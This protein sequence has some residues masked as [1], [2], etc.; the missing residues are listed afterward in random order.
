M[1]SFMSGTPG[2]SHDRHLTACCFA[3]HGTPSPLVQTSAGARQSIEPVCV[4]HPLARCEAFCQGT[5]WVV[6]N[7]CLVFR[8]FSQPCI[9]ERRLESHASLGLKSLSLILR[10][11][12]SGRFGRPVERMCMS[13]PLRDKGHQLSSQVIQVSEVADTQPLALHNAEPLLDLIHSGAVHRHLRP[14]ARL[15]GLGGIAHRWWPALL[16]LFAMP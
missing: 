6:F 10:H 5:V 4:Y 12:F 2:P 13:I 9:T 16:L 11:D 15:K 7:W 3:P 14:R 1:G 8:F